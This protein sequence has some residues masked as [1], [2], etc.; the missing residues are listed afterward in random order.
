[1]RTAT[2]EGRHSTHKRKIKSVLKKWNAKYAWSVY[3]KYGQTVLNEKDTF[4]W[5]LRGD[6]RGE[7]ESEMTAA[8]D[9]ALQTN[10]MRQKYYKQKEKANGDNINSLMK[11]E[12]HHKTACPILAK[13]QYINR[14]DTVCEQLYFNTCKEIGV[15]N[16][17]TNNGMAMYQNQSKQVQTDRT[18]P[19]HKPEIF[20]SDN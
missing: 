4:L 18:T 17:T 12:T 13:E 5:L 19:N 8:H 9:E 7:T 11:Q 1:M 14:H 16:Q 15:K 2:Q 10:S 3:Q 6:L 20:I